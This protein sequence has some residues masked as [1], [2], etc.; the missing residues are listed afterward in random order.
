MLKTLTS[1]ALSGPMLVTLIIQLT[2]SP[3]A[4]GSLSGMIVI[5]KSH[6]DETVTE[7]QSKLLDSSGS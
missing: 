1:L 2:V 6:K 7:S 3:T 4:V 5:N